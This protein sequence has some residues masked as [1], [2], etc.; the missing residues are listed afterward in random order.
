MRTDFPKPQEIDGAAFARDRALPKAHTN[1]V[2][3]FTPRAGSTWLTDIA[4]KTGKLGRPSESFNPRH[5]NKMASAMNAANLKDYCDMIARK[6]ATR[7]VAGFE[8]THHQLRAVFKGDNRFRAL[9]PNPPLFWLIR[10]DIVAQAISLY[11]MTTTRVSHSTLVDATDIAARE[12]RFVYDADRIAHWV[13]HILTAERRTEQLMT[14]AG[15]RPL[16]LWYEENVA[17]GAQSVLAAMTTHLNLP[18]IEPAHDP[19]SAHHRIATNKNAEFSAR[20]REDRQS[21]LAEVAEERS[22]WLKQLR[23]YQD[24]HAALIQSKAVA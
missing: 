21:Y 23:P 20:F 19:V 13:D 24:Q 18:P 15:W 4:S 9:Y 14:T 17:I 11:K 12:A 2:I 8:I 7:G 5:L 22:P 6:R 1:Y 16:R 10:R 3:F